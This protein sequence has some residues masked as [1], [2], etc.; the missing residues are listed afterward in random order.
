MAELHR[1]LRRGGWAILDVP[2]QGARTIED[3]SVVDP[4]ERRRRFGQEDHVRRYGADYRDRLR[5]AGFAVAVHGV[6]AVCADAER[7]RLGL[8]SP[9][10][11]EIHHCRK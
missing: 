9:A 3:P 7:V 1:V 11:G 2:I 5:E 6:A 10:S 4:A 8:A